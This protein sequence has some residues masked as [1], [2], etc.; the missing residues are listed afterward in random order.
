M[1]LVPPSLRQSQ[2]HRDDPKHVHGR[3]TGRIAYDVTDAAAGLKAVGERE[4]PIPGGSTKTIE[5]VERTSK[6]TN[7]ETWHF[8]STF[9]PD[10]T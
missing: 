7:N 2:T 5:E 6:D 9:E 8:A 1:V 4:L 3:D 10:D